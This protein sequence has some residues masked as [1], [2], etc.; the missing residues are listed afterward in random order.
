MKAFLL[1][2]GPIVLAGFTSAAPPSSAAV[3]ARMDKASEKFQAMSAKVTL[4]THTDVINENTT[5]SGTILIKKTGKSQVQALI[6]FQEPPT[7]RRTLNLSGRTAQ[8][9]FPKINTVQI[10]DLGKYREVAE[11][12]VT[13]GFGTSGR[14]LADSY[15][16][17]VLGEETLSGKSVLRLELTP[18]SADVKKVITKLDL[19]IPESGDP[20]PIEEKYYSPSNDYHLAAYSDLKINPELKGDALK[21]K[22][23]H[24]VKMEEMKK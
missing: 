17:K 24:G 10:Y 2:A 11:Q 3:L 18:K 1:L 9:Y 13:L 6:D 5:E 19:W 4:V 7:A 21:L 16:V 15:L 22:P 12:F 20:Y 14:E 23:P 8:I